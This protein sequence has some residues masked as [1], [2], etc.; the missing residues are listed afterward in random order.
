MTL[1]YHGLFSQI[2]MVLSMKTVVVLK[3]YW[4]FETHVEFMTCIYLVELHKV[5]PMMLSAY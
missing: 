2:Q 1:F 4:I 5:L 3:K